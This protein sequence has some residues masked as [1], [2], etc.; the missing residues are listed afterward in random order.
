MNRTDAALA[1][2]WVND[3]AGKTAADVTLGDVLAEV[4][5]A[6]SAHSRPQQWIRRGTQLI[7]I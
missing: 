3:E 7:V 4:F 1:V 6:A 2:D 5:T